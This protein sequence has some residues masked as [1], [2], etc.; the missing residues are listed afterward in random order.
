MKKK[1]SY[2]ISAN[3]KHDQI[4]FGFP[5]AEFVYITNSPFNEAQYIV[6]KSY[7]VKEAI[8]QLYQ[9]GYI[10]L[11]AGVNETTPTPFAAADVIATN[12][13]KLLSISWPELSLVDAPADE[14]KKQKRLAQQLYKMRPKGLSIGLNGGWTIPVNEGLY[15]ESGYR[16][17]LDAYIHFSPKFRM[18]GAVDYLKIKFESDRMDESIGIPVIVPPDNFQFEVADVPQPSVQYSVGLQY[19]LNAEKKWN[20]YIGVGYAAVSMLPYEI[21][22][23]FENEVTQVE[24]AFE[25]KINNYTLIDNFVLFQLGLE[26]CIN[27]KW[28]WHLKSAYRTNLNKEGFPGTQNV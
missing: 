19:I 7:T 9:P 15:N 3:N 25:E 27:D 4:N 8:N 24:W 21:V 12:E 10:G 23:E 22:Y 20:P 11:K 2:D 6:N 28:S 26:H 14:H 16:Y 5:S 18:W 17:G 13:Q 1:K